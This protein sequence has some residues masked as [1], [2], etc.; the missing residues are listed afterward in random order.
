MLCVDE[1]GILKSD[2]ILINLVV[3]IAF[4]AM[5]TYTYTHRHMKIFSLALSIPRSL[6]SHSPSS[7]AI[8]TYNGHR[9]S[10]NWLI[11]YFQSTCHPLWV[12]LWIKNIFSTIYLHNSIIFSVDMVESLLPSSFSTLLGI[13]LSNSDQRS[14]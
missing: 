4:A 5:H 1:R 2:Y 7:R 9:G 11:T 12:S 8:E 3:C 10:W 6:S 14:L 13:L